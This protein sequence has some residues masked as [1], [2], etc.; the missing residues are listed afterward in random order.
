MP[1]ISGKNN[2]QNV[3]YVPPILFTFAVPNNGTQN[4]PKRVAGKST[5][6]KKSIKT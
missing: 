3:K 5:A 4:P 2:Q 1:Q 6:G